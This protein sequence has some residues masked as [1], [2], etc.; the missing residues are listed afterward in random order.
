MENPSLVSHDGKITCKFPYATPTKHLDF[1]MKQINATS[2]VPKNLVIRQALQN[3]GIPP[4]IAN[5]ITDPWQNNNQKAIW[6][7][8]SEDWSYMLH[9]GIRRSLYC[10]CE[11]SV[12]ILGQYVGT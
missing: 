6:T 8:Y 3:T 10:R 11:H 2:I 1:A 5:V 12:G 4:E 9:Q 7:G